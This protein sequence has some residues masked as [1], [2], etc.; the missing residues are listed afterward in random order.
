MASRL[1]VRPWIN[2]PQS[3]SVLDGCLFVLQ[4]L[5]HPCQP[6]TPPSLQGNKT[7]FKAVSH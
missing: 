7:V 3:H 4:I 1:Y 2:V 5:Q 6:F